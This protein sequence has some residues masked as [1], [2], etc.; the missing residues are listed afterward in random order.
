[1]ANRN[2]YTFGYEG[3]DI[4][5]YLARLRANAVNVVLDVRELPLS[6]KKG[7]SKNL[8]R[9]RLASVGIEYLHEPRLGCPKGIRDQFKVDRDW[10]AYTRLFSAYIETQGESVRAVA[11]LA[12]KV[13]VCL[14]CF[15]SDYSRCHRTFVARAANRLGAPPTLHILS[16]TVV[17]DQELRAAA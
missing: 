15:E 8:F 11:N 9:E 4:D 17:A 1:M 3:M 14:V 13:N 10:D 5:E 16:R 12:R 2:L 6:R 7:F